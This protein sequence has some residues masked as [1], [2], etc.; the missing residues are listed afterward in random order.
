MNAPYDS[1]LLGVST[2]IP[3]ANV[4]AEQALL[5]A[6][7]VNN[8]AMDMVDGLRPEHFA[9]A[10]HGR[11]FLECARLIEAG[12]TADPV[13]LKGVMENAGVLADVGGVR[14][15]TQ[16]Y[17]AMVTVSMAGDYA[18]VIRDAWT[19]RQVID[20]GAEAVELAYGTRTD[21]NGEA[22]VSKAID[23]L[24]ALGEQATNTTAAASVADALDEAMNAA[25]KAARGDGPGGLM[26]GIHTLDELWGGLW[27]A[28][29]D[30]LGARSEHGKTALGMQIATNV[31]R[32]LLAEHE[33]AITAGHRHELEHVEIYSL[34]MPR[35][36]LAYRMLATETGIP[37]RDIRAGKIS[38][39]RAERLI[40]ARADLRKLPILIHDTPSMSVTEILM[41]A[42]IN[43]R[44]K[45]TRL[46]VID[47]L[48]R[49][50]P[51]ETHARLPRNEQVQSITEA[52]KTAAVSLGVPILLLAQLSRQAERREDHRPNVADIE[53][54]GERDFDNIALLWR[55]ELYLGEKPPTVS[56]KLGDE[57]RAEIEGAWW[58]RRDEMRNKAEVILA[59][60]RMGGVGSVWLDFDGPR[61][62]FSATTNYDDPQGGMF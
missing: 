39:A 17:T 7:L 27:P 31:A 45:R 25:D 21:I 18:R 16:L 9:D 37:A 10:I 5:G 3:P 40:Q 35:D 47:H 6:I 48:H 28:N 26:T 38:G 11:I 53:Y 61:T 52:L 23:R 49:V 32:G 33:A 50:K 2:R 62:R 41:R 1:P 46:T 12:R 42:R 58:K 8:K 44:K 15:L 51:A 19:R 57:K 60:T 20:I 36:H 22:A 56:E 55:P 4:Q 13:T 54:A 30:C 43:R 14:Y 24:M 29:L 59:K 34:E